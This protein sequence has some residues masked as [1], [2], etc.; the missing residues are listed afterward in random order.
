MEVDITKKTLLKAL[1]DVRDPEI[2]VLS[3]VDLGIIRNIE[4]A[5][6]EII[7]TITPT[8][9]GCPALQVMKEEII[10]QLEKSG[11]KK[12]R[13]AIDLSQPWT[14]DW[15]TPEGRKKLKSF[16]LAP[17]PIHGGNFVTMLLDPVFCPHCDS[18]NTDLRNSWGS[19]PCR[20]IYYCHNCNQPFEQFKPL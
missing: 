12:V 14:T 1:E 4:I 5:N 10:Q 3:L 17:P 19:T 6:D 2:P 20:M 7:I 15:I 18:D 11:E 8:F 13:V 9:S 16:G